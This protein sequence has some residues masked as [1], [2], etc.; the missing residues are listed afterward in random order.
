[1]LFLVENEKQQFHLNWCLLHDAVYLNDILDFL[2]NTQRVSV[3]VFFS[4][5]QFVCLKEQWVFNFKPSQYVIVKLT[6]M[7]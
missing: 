1:M 6:L 4:L 3:A 5:V 2:D 7:P